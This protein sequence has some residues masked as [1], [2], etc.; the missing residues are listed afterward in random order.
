MGCPVALQRNSAICPGC[1][2]S[3][4]GWME[5]TGA[6][7]V[8]EADGGEERACGWGKCHLTPGNS[9]LPVVFAHTQAPHGQA[10]RAA[11]GILLVYFPIVGLPVIP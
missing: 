3:C 4:G 2:V 1:I 10:P 5:T 9:L 11:R 8:P 6:D 7:R